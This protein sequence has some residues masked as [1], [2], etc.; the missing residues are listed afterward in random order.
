M[1]LSQKFKKDLE[2]INLSLLNCQEILDKK[3][4]EEKELERYESWC[5][6]VD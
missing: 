6:W 2:S 3:S 1:R 5:R 4:E